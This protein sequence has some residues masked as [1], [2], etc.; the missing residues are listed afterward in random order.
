MLSRKAIG[1]WD[2]SSISV[3]GLSEAVARRGSGPEP[4]L[5]AWVGKSEEGC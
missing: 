4:T 1:L 5:I 3:R 2:G